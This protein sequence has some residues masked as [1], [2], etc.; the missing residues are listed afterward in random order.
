MGDE[1]DIRVGHA[2]RQRALHALNEHFTAGRLTLLEFDDRTA[3]ATVA[4]TRSELDA[5]FSDLPPL[6]A[7]QS[8]AGSPLPAASASPSAPVPFR[9]RIPRD[10][11]MALTPFAALF[12]FITVGHWMF[13]L[14]IPVTA[15]VLYS[16]DD[17]DDDD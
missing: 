12:L 13:F 2:E 5:L 9:Q 8:P 3:R 1:P 4:L 7:S 16:G 15:I 14:L 17:D 6:P 10:T 11:I